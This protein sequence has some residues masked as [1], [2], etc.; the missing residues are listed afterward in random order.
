MW[1]AFFRKKM[2]V[3]HCTLSVSKIMDDFNVSAT[4]QNMHVNKPG[5]VV[6]LST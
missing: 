5:L 6:T 4:A 2:T 3:M 1:F